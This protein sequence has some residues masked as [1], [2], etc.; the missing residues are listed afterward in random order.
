MICVIRPPNPFPKRV[1]DLLSDKANLTADVRLCETQDQRSRYSCLSHCWGQSRH[2]TTLTSNIDHFKEGISWSQLPPTF[3]D[4]IIFARKF[5]FRYIWI[6]SLCIVQVRMF[7][8]TLPF[9]RLFYGLRI[10]GATQRADL[11][12]IS[13]VTH[14]TCFAVPN[15]AIYSNTDC[16]FL[17]SG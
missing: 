2:L 7:R 15:D 13:V 10:F 6:D 16:E 12:T 11:R 4:A 17:T 9:Y 8:S 1:L 5:G 3:Q 14:E